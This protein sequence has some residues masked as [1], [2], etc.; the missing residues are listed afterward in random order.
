[1]ERN[2]T[3]K[4]EYYLT[5]T[6]SLMIEKGAKVR[7]Q[8]SESWLD[9]GTIDATLETNKILLEVKANKTK[10]ETVDGVEI[11]APSFIHPSAEIMNSVIGPYS[12]IG[13]NCKIVNS[14]IEE[15]I[16]EADCEIRDAVLSRSLV[17]IEARVL[18]RG[19]GQVI[20]L[21]VGDDS[22]I[23]LA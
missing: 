15:S 23:F 5:H 13:A 4:G 10:N 22:E 17:G 11:I 2:L 16:V 9:T 6:I 20:Q 19:D 21:N 3:F 18:G 7:T 14:K 1:M 12:S 8:K